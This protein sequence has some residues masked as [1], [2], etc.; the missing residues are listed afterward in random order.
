MR[1]NAEATGEKY[2][3]IAK[4]MGVEGVDA[5]SLEEARRAACDAV[6]QLSKD[7][8]IPENLKGIVREEDLDFLAQSAMDDACRPGNPKDPTK[9]DIIGLYRAL[10]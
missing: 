5:M 4:A 9:E 10:L 7:V 3:D 8:G 2:R 1:Y 6:A